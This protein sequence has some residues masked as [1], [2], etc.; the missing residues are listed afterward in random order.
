MNILF[1]SAIT[2]LHVKTT[3]GRHTVPQRWQGCNRAES[4]SGGDVCCGA[5]VVFC[6]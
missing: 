1:F 4:R 2:K 3:L 5:T 6:A